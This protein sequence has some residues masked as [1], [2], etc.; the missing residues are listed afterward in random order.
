MLILDRLALP[1]IAANKKKISANSARGGEI[2]GQ[3]KAQHVGI[4]TKPTGRKY[5]LNAVR[6]VH[7]RVF[8]L[9]RI[10]FISTGCR[11]TM[12]ACALADYEGYG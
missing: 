9:I 1:F 7:E 8:L 11:R 6:V 4:D 12:P 2:D 10:S 3:R 5:K